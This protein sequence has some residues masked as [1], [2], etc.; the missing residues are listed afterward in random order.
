MARVIVIDDEE[1]IRITLQQALEYD[2]HTVVVAVDGDDGLRK[3]AEFPAVLVITD[4]MMP[5]KEGIETIMELRK[6]RPDVKIVAISGGIRG[7]SLSFLEMAKKLG[8]DTILK[9]PFEMKILLATVN[10]CMRKPASPRC[11]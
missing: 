6:M 9:K 8:A 10:E 4:I 3:I 7:S 1:L 5:N 2:H 11:A